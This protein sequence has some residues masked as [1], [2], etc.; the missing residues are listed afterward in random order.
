VNGL[1]G[2]ILTKLDCDAKGGAALSVAHEA[3]VPVLYICAG[4][5]YEDFQLFDS[6]WFVER[7][8]PEAS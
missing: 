7:M 2:I 4:Q 3:K 5:E 8:L 6:E 1:D